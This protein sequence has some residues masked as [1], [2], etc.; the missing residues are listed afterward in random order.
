MT[1]KLDPKEAK[2]LADIL[3]LTLDEQPGASMTALQKIQQRAKQDGITGG[4]LKNIFTRIAS[5]LP[6]SGDSRRGEQSGAP[7]GTFNSTQLRST[8]ASQAASISLLEQRLALLQ[9]RL[10]QNEASRRQEHHTMM[11]AARRLGV[12]T[13]IGG[14]VM[15]AILTA[16]AAYELPAPAAMVPQARFL[17]P[18]EQMAQPRGAQPRVAPAHLPPTSGSTEQLVEPGFSPPMRD[19]DDTAPGPE[20]PPDAARRGLEGVVQLLVY[21]E[22][23]GHVAGIAVSRGS[24]SAELDVAAEQAV[25]LWKFRPAM[26]DGVPIANSTNLTLRFVLHR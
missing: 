20:Y 21:V 22:K 10:S 9:A 16:L 1:E 4:A 18:G 6:R 26:R 8:I 15:G 7:G 17:P 25:R 24:G 23:D 19:P 5:D 11:W 13:A 2:I 14:L 3:A 12:K